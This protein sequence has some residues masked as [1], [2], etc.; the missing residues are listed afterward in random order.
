MTAIYRMKIRQVQL[1]NV[2]KFDY[3]PFDNIYIVPKNLSTDLAAK[4]FR[5]CLIME[6]NE[7]LK[8]ALRKVNIQQQREIKMRR[9]DNAYKWK[10]VKT[11]EEIQQ[12]TEFLAEGEWVGI[13]PTYAITA[14]KSTEETK[15]KQLQYVITHAVKSIHNRLAVMPTIL[16]QTP[17]RT[18][19]A[20]CA[21]CKHVAEYYQN[22]CV[23]ASYK[24]KGQIFLNDLDGV[25]NDIRV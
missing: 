18:L 16:L 1:R 22:R 2:S 8:E 11:A 13:I 7:P 3:F 6:I 20:L 17:K 5:W 19:P 21:M 10:R 4:M 23:P 25:D 24:C 15:Q 14:P 9:D 12:S